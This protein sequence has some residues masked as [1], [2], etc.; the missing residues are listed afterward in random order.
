[1]VSR[2]RTNTVEFCSV[3]RAY[4]QLSNSSTSGCGFSYFLN[5]PSYFVN[6]AGSITQLTTDTLLNNEQKVFD[7]YK[8]RSL[9]MTLLPWVTGQI[10]VNTAVAF[11]APTDPLLLVAL[12]YDDAALI[13]NINKALNAQNRSIYHAYTDRVQ[14]VTMRQRDP[15]DKMKWCNLGA[16]AP[17]LTSP[18]DPNNPVKLA[19]IKLW[20]QA[21]QL[22]NTTEMSVILE[23]TVLF[24]GAYTI[25]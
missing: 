24:K 25:G 7:E 21:F 3:I 4:H 19:S 18:P 16:I 17:S 20:K 13:T 8:V 22:A 14:V 5:Y 9:K 23:W 10:R 15:V 11:T 6:S 2:L 1:M 12:D